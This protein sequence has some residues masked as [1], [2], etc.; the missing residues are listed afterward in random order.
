MG[1]SAS[2]PPAPAGAVASPSY[3]GEMKLDRGAMMLSKIEFY[4]K[5]YL[6]F[7]ILLFILLIV[8]VFAVVSGLASRAMGQQ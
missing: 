6:P 7:A 8:L 1:V 4:L 3:N 2:G 5:A